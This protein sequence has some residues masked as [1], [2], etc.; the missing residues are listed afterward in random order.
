MHNTKM[1]ECRRIQN[2]SFPLDMA[3]L[4]SALDRH[5][6]SMTVTE[7]TV[8]GLVDSMKKECR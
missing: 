3:V 4:V 8:G 5:C 7:A 6:V 1:P 2:Q